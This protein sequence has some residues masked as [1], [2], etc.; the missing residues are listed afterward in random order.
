MPLPAFRSMKNVG[1]SQGGGEKRAS[2]MAQ[3][4]ANWGV[5]PSKAA[6]SGAN[7]AY[8]ALPSDCECRYSSGL[9]GGRCLPAKGGVVAFVIKSTRL[10]P[11]FPTQQPVSNFA[12]AFC[13][14]QSKSQ[15]QDED[16]QGHEKAFS[17]VGHGQSHAPPRRNQP[18][19]NRFDQEASSQ[20]ARHDC[21]SRLHGK[22]CSGGTW[23]L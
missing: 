13:H 19:G 20:S 12:I 8:Y 16:P 23:P 15:D 5:W 9:A 3:I 21:G 17:L 18:L 6:E 2:E 11:C 1:C 10:N 4:W 22:D 14:D 7:W